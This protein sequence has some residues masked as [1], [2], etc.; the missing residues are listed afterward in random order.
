MDVA[1]KVTHRHHTE[2]RRLE[3]LSLECKSNSEGPE[4]QAVDHA[5]PPENFSVDIGL[6]LYGIK[7]S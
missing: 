6:L 2:S 4:I 1:E 3:D 7:W 5:A